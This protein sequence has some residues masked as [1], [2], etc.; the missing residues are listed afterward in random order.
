[1][2]KHRA[3]KQPMIKKRYEIIESFKRGKDLELRILRKA[4]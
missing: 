3:H 4:S 2:H 1:M